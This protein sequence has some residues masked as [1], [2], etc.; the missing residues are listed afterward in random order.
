MLLTGLLRS[1]WSQSYDRNVTHSQEVDWFTLGLVVV[2]ALPSITAQDGA[3]ESHTHGGEP[4]WLVQFPHW[5]L[6]DL[7]VWSEWCG[8][9]RASH[10]VVVTWIEEFQH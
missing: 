4:V 2:S 3:V 8:I 7:C 10:N 1:V 5:Y 6:I 9:R